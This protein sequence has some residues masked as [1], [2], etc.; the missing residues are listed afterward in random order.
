[1]P[2]NELLETL[3]AKLSVKLYLD[4]LPDASSYAISL[5]RFSKAVTDCDIFPIEVGLFQ[6]KLHLPFAYPARLQ[7]L[8][9]FTCVPVLLEY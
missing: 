8:V 3:G 4:V 7:R 1:M 6:D 2:V 9:A 5:K